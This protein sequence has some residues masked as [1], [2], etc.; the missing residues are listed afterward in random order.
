MF[1][2]IVEL[3]STEAFV[4]TL[5]LLDRQLDL[6]LPGYVYHIYI[7]CETNGWIYQQMTG[8]IR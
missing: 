3:Q 4:V 7:I 2:T 8:F 6:Q 1:Q 5:P